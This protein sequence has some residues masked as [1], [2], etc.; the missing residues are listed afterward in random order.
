MDK[1]L[2]KLP[3]WITSPRL[4]KL[5]ESIEFRFFLPAGIRSEGLSIFP[6]YLELANPGK[7]FVA[8]GDLA[9]LDTL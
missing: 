3:Q 9:W 5:G 1:T 6:R 7:A 8:G 2:L 4:L